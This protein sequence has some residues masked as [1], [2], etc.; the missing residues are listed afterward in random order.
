MN[1]ILATMDRDSTDPRDRFFSLLGLMPDQQVLL[2]DYSKTL[3]RTLANVFFVIA[4]E[5]QLLPFD[6]A[7]TRPWSRPWSAQRP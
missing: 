7:P 6:T 3:E 5:E 2:S 4:Q 1:L